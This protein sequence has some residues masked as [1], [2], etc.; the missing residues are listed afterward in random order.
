M[1][2]STFYTRRVL[3]TL[4]GQKNN[5]GEFLGR[6][7]KNDGT[8]P[9]E[10]GQAVRSVA[11][12]KL[13]EDCYEGDPNYVKT[14]QPG[15]VPT[16]TAV[17]PSFGRLDGFGRGANNVFGF[18]S[19]ARNMEG[20]DQ[21]AKELQSSAAS[22]HRGE[23]GALARGAGECDLPP[24]SHGRHAQERRGRDLR[25]HGA[26][27]DQ[28]GND[29]NRR[30]DGCVGRIRVAVRSSGH[31]HDSR[32]TGLL[33]P[34]QMAFAEQISFSPWHGLTAHRPAGALNEARREA[35]RQ[36]A[37]HRHDRNGV[38]YREP[39]GQSDF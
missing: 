13:Q 24:A 14:W 20:C 38:R 37:K 31:N 19:P 1:E 16:K 17:A 10:F 35:Y 12:L 22:R 4:V 28:S 23:I 11:R 7:P 9:E 30:P 15:D 33:S 32:R 6:L 29:A 3:E 25:L 8:K 36:M 39:T 5:P 18:A 27:P 26:A 21:A 34:A 2:T